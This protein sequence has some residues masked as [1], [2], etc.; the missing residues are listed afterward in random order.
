MRRNFAQ[1]MKRNLTALAARLVRRPPLTPAQLLELRP[2]RI[3]V[4]RQQNQM[5]DMVC[6]TPI[7][8]ALR[9]NFPGAEIGLVTSP[10]NVDVVRHNPHLD[11]IFIFEQRMWRNPFRLVAFLRRIRN[12]R[13]EL[14][15]VLASVSFSVTSAG[16]GL[17]SGAKWVVGAES[18]PFGLDLSR[19]VFSLELPSGPEVTGHA[20]E[21]GLAP[22]RAVGIA[23]SDPGTV[24]QPS[25]GE[26]AA[27]ERIRL[28]LGLEPGYWAIHPGAGKKQN[29][30]P[31]SGFASVARRA[32]GQ[33]A[34]VLL[35]HGPADQEALAEL[36]RLLA[37][38]IGRGVL[39][40][41]PCPVGVGAALLDGADRFL[42]NDTGVMHIAGALGVPT[43]ALFGP[44]DPGHWKPPVDSVTAVRSPART[45]DDRGEEF[46][47]LENIDPQTVWAAWSAL[48]SR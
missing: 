13:P 19:F 39:T 7:F 33:G 48:P 10:V 38:Q 17:A 27:A 42:C 25:P 45:P 46:G 28:D 3:L 6:A 21:H 9:E 47:W 41:P 40:A 15:F 34:R 30:W 36:E 8:R 29:L 12:F 14:A 11:R 4:V 22:L 1:S 44:T 37:D 35:L 5:G 20:I 32:L 43:V 18:G 24:V 23:P 16:I 26:R 31:A 2:A